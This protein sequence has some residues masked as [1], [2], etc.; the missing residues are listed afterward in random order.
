[1]MIQRVSSVVYFNMSSLILTD[2]LKLGFD[3]T[4]LPVFMAIDAAVTRLISRPILN[5]CLSY[6]EKLHCRCIV[7]SVVARTSGLL[8]LETYH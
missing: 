5:H 4:L 1:M 7:L 2:V 3:F 6:F 8:G